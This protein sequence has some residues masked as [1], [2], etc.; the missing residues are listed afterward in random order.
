MNEFPDPLISGG[1]A[2]V[3]SLCKLDYPTVDGMR[4]VR[5]T[6]EETGDVYAQYILEESEGRLPAAGAYHLQA[7]CH[8]E[9]ASGRLSIYVRDSD[10]NSSNVTYG[11]ISA[12]ET[13]TCDLE[14]AI[15]PGSTELVISLRPSNT[16]GV[17]IMMSQI[18]LES[19][20]TYDA[21]G[22]GPTVFAGDTMPFAG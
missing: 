10:G 19:K 1:F 22:T 4:W 15:P 13:K 3:V 7:L 8:A 6:V 9:Q 16:V 11:E 12:G 5:A 14:F 21:R 17:S 18:Q 2:P 20:A